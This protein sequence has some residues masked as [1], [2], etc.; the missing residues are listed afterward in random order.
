MNQSTSQPVEQASRVAEEYRHLRQ[1][2]GLWIP[3]DAGVLRLA[4]ADRVDFLQRMTSNN[5]AI[6]QPGDGAVTVLTSPV[7]RIEHV[8]TVLCQP[9]ELWLLPAAGETQALARSL[10]GKIF[11]MDQVTVEE[12][13]GYARARLMGPQAWTL[14]AGLGVELAQASEGRF[15]EREGAVFVKQEGF[16]VPGA[17]ILALSPTL[18]AWTQRLQEAG[19]RLLEDDQAVTI[20]RVELGRP[21][22]GHELTGEYNPLEAG[23][24]WACAENKGCYTGQEIIARQITY[25]KVTKTL[26]GLAPDPA[27][28]ATLPVG[29]PVTADGREVG[30]V[31]SSAYSPGLEAPVALGIVKRPHNRP[32]VALEVQ[33]QP[34][35]VA[36]LPFLE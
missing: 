11:F 18:A 9:E 26:V 8:F 13:A 22:P 27:A 6:L 20:R 5:M 7:A 28:G 24:A 1:G 15:L 34:V 12:M 35:T 30:R 16:G 29:A 17:V 36:D 10:R 4:G 32:G 14:L 31:T 3:P 25:D 19:A 33:G 2:A 21:W 23:L